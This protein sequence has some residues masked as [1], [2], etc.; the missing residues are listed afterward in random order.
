MHV[1]DGYLFGSITRMEFQFTPGAERA[2]QRATDWSD[3]SHCT[4]ISAQALLLGLLA[5]TECRAAIK[6]ESLQIDTPEVL[7]KWP[8]F[9][10][11]N[12]DK[13][14]NRQFGENTLVA[15]TKV[16]KSV[17]I[18]R[19]S[20]DVQAS[21]AAT[22]DLLQDL[23]TPLILATEHLLLGLAAA[24]HEAAVWL[25]ELGLNP[26]ALVEEIHQQY[27]ISPE[28]LPLDDLEP[29]E[30]DQPDVSVNSPA[31]PPTDG[32]PPTAPRQSES[33]DPLIRL[34]HQERIR[35]LRVIDAAANRGREGLRAVED[36]V[37]FVL[38]DP[39]LTDRL[40]RLRHEL[41]SVLSAVPLRERL[42]ARETQA[43]V[44]T[45][46]DT[47][48]ENRRQDATSVMAA[49]FTRIQEALRSL[50]EFGKV[51]DSRMANAIKQI[52]YEVYTLQR[53]VETTRSSTEILADARLYVL[54]D[55]CASERHF[56]SLVASL[57]AAGVHV[58]QFREKR[59]D[60]RRLLERARVLRDMTRSTRT[61][62]VINDRPDLAVLAR[63][64]GVHVGQEDLSV[65]DARTL[66]G[67]GAL[68]GVSTH[69][70]EQARQA[71][72]DGANY[73]GVG[74]TFPS[75]TK[76]FERFPGVELLRAVASEIRL[77]AFAIGGINRENLPDVLSTG[78]HRIAV[79]GAV[80]KSDDPAAAAKELLAS[81]VSC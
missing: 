60:E 35:L 80:A 66:V 21:L 23:P 14:G 72:M 57:V 17:P 5:E 81:L 24:E 9:A 27:G 54:I 43:D 19:F 20:A 1:A 73:I 45:S 22:Y 69:S 34:S 46:L 74:P 42:A 67:P 68:V 49:N 40:K 58:I 44:G 6:L 76:P 28:P 50:E 56:R 39:H 41:T 52:R 18:E 12:P 55:G 38:D 70:I 65:K 13:T 29:I 25:R 71:V 79:S 30:I 78:I 64:D 31:D 62:F 7:R 51:L 8:C 59:L 53:T 36:Y 16:D 75:D 61:L 11:P 63:A 4:Q 48:S 10:A 37:R 47:P 15:R 3:C 77:P 33:A 26:H 2:I 32:P